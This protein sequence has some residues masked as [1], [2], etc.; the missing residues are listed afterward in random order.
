MKLSECDINK[1]YSVL[2]IQ[3]DDDVKRRF[4]MLGMTHGAAIEVLGKKKNGAL[5]F[6][7]RGTRFAIGAK[8][9]NGIFVEVKKSE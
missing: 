9:A 6:K 5:I 2:D 1:K 8:F 7:M 4:E 3:L